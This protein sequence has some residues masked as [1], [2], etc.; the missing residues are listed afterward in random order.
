MDKASAEGVEN[1]KLLEVVAEIEGG[2]GIRGGP[3]FCMVDSTP[4]RSSSNSTFI[5]HVNQLFLVNIVIL[6][7]GI[8][9]SDAIDD[10]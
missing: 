8:V 1:A 9:W 2:G 4:H 10:V 7:F 5:D 3:G 6:D